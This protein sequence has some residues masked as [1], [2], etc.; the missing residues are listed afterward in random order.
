ML[1][2]V[3]YHRHPLTRAK[4][5]HRKRLLH[6]GFEPTT[7]LICD[8]RM[9]P[10]GIRSHDLSV[11]NREVGTTVPLMPLKSFD[12]YYSLLVGT[13]NGLSQVLYTT[14]YRRHKRSGIRRRHI[15]VW[16]NLGFEPTKERGGMNPANES[17]VQI[18]STV[19]HGIRSRDLYILS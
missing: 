12:V 3:C 5:I 2:T 10:T 19:V 7:S 4:E 8:S 11:L 13:P 6:L 9:I 17:C 1:Y 14:C 16:A 18:G 15:G